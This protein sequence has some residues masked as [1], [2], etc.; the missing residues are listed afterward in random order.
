L[1]IPGGSFQACHART[2]PKSAIDQHQTR[3]GA[4]QARTFRKIG[5][6]RA[7]G[8]GRP[9]GFSVTPDPRARPRHRR[10]AEAEPT[11]VI[12]FT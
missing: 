4:V 10:D 12:A 8:T 3:R 9:R 6:F 1:Y 11:E 5:P 7:C 2:S